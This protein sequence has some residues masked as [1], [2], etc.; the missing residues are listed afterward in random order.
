[1][2]IIMVVGLL[3][4]LCGIFIAAFI[5]IQGDEQFSWKTAFTWG[6][7]AIKRMYKDLYFGGKSW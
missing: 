6:Y 4:V 5:A 2:K 3:Y 1:M 7:K